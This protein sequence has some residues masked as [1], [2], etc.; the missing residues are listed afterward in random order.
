MAE[1][2]NKVFRTQCVAVL[3]NL[4]TVLP[5][6]WGIAMVWNN[7]AGKHLVD[8][9]KAMHLLHDIDPFHSLALM[10][11]AIAGVCL[12]VAGLISG[13]YDNK[14]LYTRMMSPLVYCGTI[15]VSAPGRIR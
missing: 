6:A 5:T 12:F 3:G 10:Y 2:V 13:Y 7:V 4:A 14:A 15:T 11:A 9:A 8:P 1:L